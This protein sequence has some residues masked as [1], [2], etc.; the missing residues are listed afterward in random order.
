M[1]LV[2][3]WFRILNGRAPMLS[4][5]ITRECPLHCP[6]CY[7]YND[8]H[9]GGGTTLNLGAS[10]SQ[11]QTVGVRKQLG[12]SWDVTTSVDPSKVNPGSEIVTAFLEWVHRY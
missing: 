7:A 12:P 3:A 11:F 5:E 4:I 10:A 8:S 2:S 9:L 6:G 1:E